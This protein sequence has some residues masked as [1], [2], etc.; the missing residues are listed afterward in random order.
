MGLRLTD[1]EPKGFGCPWLLVCYRRVQYYHSIQAK[2]MAYGSPVQGILPNFQDEFS[3]VYDIDRP[4][5]DKV[6]R[7]ILNEETKQNS[8]KTLL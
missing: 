3:I 5:A 1:S 8:A 2:F 6:A 7:V 4:T